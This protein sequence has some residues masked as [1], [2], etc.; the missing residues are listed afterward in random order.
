MVLARDYPGLARRYRLSSVPLTVIESEG[1]S[2]S[3]LG[4]RPEADFRDALLE[5]DGDA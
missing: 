1:A 5:A 2:R 4:A 3:V